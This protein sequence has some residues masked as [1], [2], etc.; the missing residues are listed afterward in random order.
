MSAQNTTAE[1]IANVTITTTPN[2]T[3]IRD[4]NAERQQF[5]R[6]F[7]NTA[8]TGQGSE[9]LEDSTM[10]SFH[11]LNYFW[12]LYNGFLTK[13]SRPFPLGVQG[14][15][16][17]LKSDR[18]TCKARGYDLDEND[19]KRY[20]YVLGHMQKLQAV[21]V[22]LD[23]AILKRKIAYAENQVSAVQTPAVPV[24]QGIKQ[25]V[26]RQGAVWNKDR[27]VT[28]AEALQIASITEEKLSDMLKDSKIYS[29]KVICIYSD[30]ER[31]SYEKNGA[32]I[33]YIIEKRA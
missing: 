18:E 6:N 2:A 33:R 10:F 5:M 31:L 19:L 27:D 29:T 16:D 11:D 4:R 21:I 28:K 32:A 17:K 7:L 22:Q 15:V 12:G 25:G 14:E 23:R 3:D 9:K 8:R 1:V 13:Q 24:S 26:I 20:L 30:R